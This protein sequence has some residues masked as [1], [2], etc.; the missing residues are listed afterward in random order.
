M[1][2]TDYSEEVSDIV[3]ALETKFQEKLVS[4]SNIKTIN[5]KSLLGSGNITIEGSGGSFEPELVYRC[6]SFN[7]TYINT[8]ATNRVELYKLGTIYFLRYFIT[9][10]T[11]TS[12]STDYLINNDSIPSEYRPSSN[13]TF[14]ISTSS[15]H[16]AKL[17]INTSG[18]VRIS[19]D[20]DSVA[21]SFAGS[22]T[23]WWAEAVSPVVALSLSSSSVSYGSSV[24][25][26]ATV[27]QSGS[28]VSGETV[29]FYDGST[30]IGTG[31]TNS[32][33]VATLT[34][35]DFS[36]AT[37]SLTASYSSV[38]SSAESLTVSKATPTISLSTSSAT[39]TYSTSITLSG[40][41]SAGTGA[42]VKIYDGN[43]LLDTVTT[44]TGGAFTCSTS[45]LTVG[46]H[47]LTAVFEGNTNYN[48]VTSSAVSVTVSKITSTISLSTS[49]ASVTYGTSVTLSG[50]L[51]V[52]S[53]KSVE[54]YDG[55]TLVD[56]LT[57][58]TNGA[59]SY[60]SSSLSVGSHSFIAVYDGDSTH[61]SVTSSSV[62]VTV[63]QAPSYDAIALT[64]DKD[65]I[66]AYDGESAILTAQLQDNGTDAP[67]SGVSLS[68][69][70]KKGS[71][72]ID[73]KTATTGADG[74]CNVSYVGEGTGDINI[75]ASVGMIVSE[76]YSIE[77]C[78]KYNH[79][80]IN[81]WS[82]NN[83]PTVST[84]D[85]GITIST[86]SN[87]EKRV[88]F[89]QAFTSSDNVE[90]S[91][92]WVGGVSNA[93]CMGCAFLR[94]DNIDSEKFFSRSCPS[95]FAYK[96]KSSGSAS[97]SQESLATGD[98]I[99]LQYVNGVCKAYKNDTLIASTTT[100][101]YNFY[102]GFYTN[103]GR[104]QT[105]KDIEIKAL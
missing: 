23:Y 32:S 4:G 82:T 48:S 7:S 85:E 62:S 20:A 10:N 43:T 9:T 94:T 35:S 2:D 12:A 33:G 78:I 8:S 1:T 64:S 60:S 70:I 25:L 84:S 103:S 76:T 31:T 105:I 24:T 27:T 97:Y 14:H 72:V 18:Q 75:Q 46:S 3:D 63:T 5:H 17:T 100:S 68:F 55:N 88:Y 61:T 67:I 52:G 49:S 40:T 80:D 22:Q 56:T 42:T 30:S 28:P 87:G 95:Q 83:N 44:G 50:T 38:T 79:L 69:V 73:T 81:G 54:L 96:F 58:T 21:I 102:F 51:S 59:F 98:T 57:T 19:A 47:S 53:G 37:H 92:V 11:L 99:K 89:A 74:S 77:D 45:S 15:N 36:V 26:T 104:S 34:K 65:I 13:I 41:L 39:P 86:S 93:Q 71:T 66:S 101:I 29:T 90:M 6:S 91:F 16:N